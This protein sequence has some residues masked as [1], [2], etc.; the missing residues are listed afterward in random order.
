MTEPTRPDEIRRARRAGLAPSP[1]A[2]PRATRVATPDDP[3]VRTG[4][5]FSAGLEA[6]FRTIHASVAARACAACREELG[7]P[8]LAYRIVLRCEGPRG[9]T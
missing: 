6:R 7:A 3:A 4:E 1:P 8:E 5:G 9:G 2:G